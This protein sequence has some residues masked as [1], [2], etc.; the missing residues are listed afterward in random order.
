MQSMHVLLY[1][2]TT[3]RDPLAQGT[4][5]KVAMKMSGVRCWDPPCTR[6]YWIPNNKA[7]KTRH[8]DPHRRPLPPPIPRPNSIFSL[9]P[10]PPHPILHHPTPPIRRLRVPRRRHRSIPSRPNSARPLRSA[11]ALGSSME[12]LRRDGAVRGSVALRRRPHMK[13]ACMLRGGFL[14]AACFKDEHADVEQAGY[15]VIDLEGVVVVVGGRRCV[16]KRT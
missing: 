13:T 9:L 11:E 14:V 6:I 12:K 2:I 4:T 3:C 1:F 16:L 8:T 10:T 15:A 5:Y 7:T